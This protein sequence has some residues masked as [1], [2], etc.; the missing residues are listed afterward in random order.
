[1]HAL[2]RFVRKQTIGETNYGEELSAIAY[3]A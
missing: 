2:Q 3:I 1:M